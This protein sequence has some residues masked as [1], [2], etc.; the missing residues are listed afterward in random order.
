MS[1]EVS[2]DDSLLGFNPFAPS[3][4]SQE[5]N[6]DDDNCNNNTNLASQSSSLLSSPSCPITTASTS[7][8]HHHP[9]HEDDEDVSKRNMTKVNVN[10]PDVIEMA[11][12]W[13][14]DT[15]QNSN[16]FKS[17]AFMMENPDELYWVVR[18]SGKQRKIKAEINPVRL[19]MDV[20]ETNGLSFSS[21]EKLKSRKDHKFVQYVEFPMMFKEYDIVLINQ[22]VPFHQSILSE[23]GSVLTPNKWAVFEDED[24]SEALEWNRDM[25]SY[26]RAQLRR[27]ARIKATSNN[28]TVARYGID[29]DRSRRVHAELYLMQ[30]ILE[31]VEEKQKRRIQLDL[32]RKKELENMTET[33]DNSTSSEMMDE[34]YEQS[35]N[36]DDD[37][38]ARMYGYI[39]YNAG[40]KTKEPLRPGDII[41]YYNPMFTAGDKRGLRTAQVLIVRTK[42]TMKQTNLPM[43]T[44]SN[45]EVIPPETQVR[46]ANIL[47][48][49]NRE[50]ITHSHGIYRRIET[51]KLK[52]MVFDIEK[53]P[54]CVL[55][56]E[57][58]RIGKILEN[59][60]RRFQEKLKEDG[61]EGFG[62]LINKIG[63]GSKKST[64]KTNTNSIASF[65]ISKN[66]T[67]A[68]NVKPMN[69]KKRPARVTAKLSDDSEGYESDSEGVFENSFKNKKLHKSNKHRKI[70]NANSLS[71]PK[72]LSIPCKAKTAKSFD[73]CTPNSSST[74]HDVDTETPSTHSSNDIS[75]EKVPSESFIADDRSNESSEHDSNF[76]ASRVQQKD[77]FQSINSASSNESSDSNSDLKISRVK[78]K[79]NM[80]SID[81]AFFVKGRATTNSRDVENQMLATFEKKNQLPSMSS[82]KNKINSGTITKRPLQLMLTKA[83]SKSAD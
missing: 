13:V 3:Q 39:S 1:D 60:M 50:V 78:Q 70:G 37:D 77:Q 12:I 67:S 61:L 57:T 32:D 16:F 41:T 14:D 34:P 64:S 63:K 82:V 9:H 42:R 54:Q 49:K 24:K 8:R 30:R 20:R 76:K 75:F 40:S 47:D 11:K 56:K 65:F 4:Q 79:H 23:K 35:F 74:P 81:S 44:L 17:D 25:C 53:F 55:E 7:R 19:V 31:A 73:L 6:D 22:I 72:L 2:D 18:N 26:Y 58:D 29:Y 68:K 46:R 36:K 52:D 10:V 21:K 62:G 51:F 43:L 69:S 71:V 48:Y 33:S 15:I 28:S 59:N 80:K 27:S 5:L 83:N 66:T 45:G 38:D